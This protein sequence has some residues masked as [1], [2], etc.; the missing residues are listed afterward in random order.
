M[1]INPDTS[2]TYLTKNNDETLVHSPLDEK[3][4][5]IEKTDNNEV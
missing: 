3:Y 4:H 5:T 1:K 2:V